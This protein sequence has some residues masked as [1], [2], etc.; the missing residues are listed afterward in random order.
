MKQEMANRRS[1]FDDQLKTLQT[2]R[3]GT[4]TPSRSH[5]QLRAWHRRRNLTTS[6]GAHYIN[7]DGQEHLKP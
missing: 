7:T 1:S 4:N 5:Q 2:N 3:P 6:K